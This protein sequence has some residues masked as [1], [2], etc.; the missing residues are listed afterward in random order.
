MDI[1]N[2][3]LT[4]Q[5]SD[6]SDTPPDILPSLGACWRYEDWDRQWQGINPT[7]HPMGGLYVRLHGINKY[8]RKD[9]RGHRETCDHMA[10]VLQ[11]D[12][13]D[14]GEFCSLRGQNVP[15]YMLQGTS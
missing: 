8:C 3:F 12:T 2:P 5:A 15:L 4:F 13:E 11:N 7:P 9:L 10:C 14:V 6:E 1:P